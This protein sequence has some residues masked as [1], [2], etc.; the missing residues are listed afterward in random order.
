MVN[1]C[2][3]EDNKCEIQSNKVI[4]FPFTNKQTLHRKK[5]SQHTRIIFQL[6]HHYITPAIR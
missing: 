5:S 2:F 6:I 3:E 1:S 4:D